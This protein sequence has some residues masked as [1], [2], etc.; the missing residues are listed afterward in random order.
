MLKKDRGKRWRCGA[1]PRTY[2][3]AGRKDERS[4][5]FKGLENKEK[6]LE[7]LVEVPEGSLLV[8]TGASAAFWRT[9]RWM[10][11]PISF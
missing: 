1:K 9:S 2:S 3:S 4:L 10:V 5:V 11:H 6:V 7:S 8:L